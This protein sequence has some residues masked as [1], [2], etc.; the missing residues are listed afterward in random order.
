MFKGC[1][2]SSSC[3]YG[4]CLS[5]DACGVS[6]MKFLIPPWLSYSN[7]LMKIC[8]LSI[9]PHFAV[10]SFERNDSPNYHFYYSYP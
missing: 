8:P 1:R 4:P 9:T 5:H 3:S 6:F 7:H 10:A 2:P